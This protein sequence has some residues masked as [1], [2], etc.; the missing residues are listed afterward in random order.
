[1]VGSHRAPKPPSRGPGHRLCALRGARLVHLPIGCKATIADIPSMAMALLMLFEV[2]VAS[3]VSATSRVVHVTV[4]SSPLVAVNIA[5]IIVL[6]IAA[7]PDAL[8]DYRYS[9]LITA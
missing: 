3:P 6:L 7:K 8:A 9:R 5:G 4:T 1:M 2:A